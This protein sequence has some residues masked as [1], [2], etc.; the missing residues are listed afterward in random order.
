M[1]EQIQ[2][3]SQNSEAYQA[4]HDIIVNDYVQIREIFN[5]LFKLNFPNLVKEAANKAL[6]NLHEYLGVFLK[7][8]NKQEEAKIQEKLK[9]TSA[10]YTLNK[11]IEN[12]ARYGKEIDFE[13]LSRSIKSAL[14]VDDSFLENIFSNASEIIP[15]LNKTQLTVILSLFFINFLGLPEDAVTPFQLELLVNMLFK[16]KDIQVML[17]DSQKMYLVSLGVSTFNQFSGGS[18]NDFLKRRYPLKFESEIKPFILSHKELK[19]KQLIEYYDK[20]SL[21][22]YN[23]TPVGTAIAYLLAK[24]NIPALSVDIIKN[25]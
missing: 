6:E 1:D 7:D 19:L 20:N 18:A 25:L 23:L 12:A 21:V 13:L 8:I 3:V 2:K 15:R 5:D 4:G 9:K 24:E 11:S 14:L 10:Q 16:G 22:Q 17:R